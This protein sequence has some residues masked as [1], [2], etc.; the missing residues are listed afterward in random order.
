MLVRTP[1]SENQEHPM[2]WL[3][4]EEGRSGS[5]KPGLMRVAQYQ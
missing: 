4:A 5:Q 1:G 3:G 2:S